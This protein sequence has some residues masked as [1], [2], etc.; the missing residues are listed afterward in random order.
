MNHSSNT[1]ENAE[2]FGFCSEDLTLLGSGYMNNQ[3]LRFAREPF[4]DMIVPARFSMVGSLVMMLIIG[5]FFYGWWYAWLMYGPPLGA[6]G[7]FVA[8]AATCLGVLGPP[9]GH[10]WRIRHLN[11]V[12]PLVEYDRKTDLVSILA[13]RHTFS[14][15]QLFCLLLIAAPHGEDVYSEFHCL[16][17][18]PSG[19]E[20]YLLMTDIMSTPRVFEQAAREFCSRARLPLVKSM[21][22]KR[23]ETTDCWQVE[24]LVQRR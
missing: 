21:P 12:S 5:L 16:V 7:W 1:W 22:R 13:G 3:R 17:D 23:M 8:V 10:Y 11:S 6:F 4:R 14:P 15:D 2:R 18:L 20:R 19:R 9:V 24:V